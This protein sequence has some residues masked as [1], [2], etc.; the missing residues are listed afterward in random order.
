MSKPAAPPPRTRIPSD[1]ELAPGF[2]DFVKRV[3]GYRPPQTGKSRNE[4]P[5]SHAK[6]MRLSNKT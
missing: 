2:G 4:G 3:I 6:H 1:D 5:K